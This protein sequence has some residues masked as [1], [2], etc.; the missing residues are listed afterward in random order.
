LRVKKLLF[1]Q[2]VLKKGKQMSR[3]IV[4]GNWK[5]NKTASEALLLAKEIE[6]RDLPSDV[7][8]LLAPPAVYLQNIRQVVGSKTGLYVAA[9]NCHH[10]QRGAFTGEISVEM[11]KSI[12]IQHVIIGHSERREYFKETNAMIAKKVDLL[13]SKEMTPIFCCGEPLPIRKKGKHVKYVATQIKESLFH[14]VHAD[15]KKV[16]IAYEPIWAIG[17]GLTATPE[18][19]QDMHFEL[20]KVIR[21]K[22]GNEIADN[23]S[24]L[25]GGSCNAAN[26]K[27]LFAQPDI[28]GGL[29]GGASLKVDDFC[30]IVNSF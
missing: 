6:Q 21:K 24:I 27:T 30:T 10:E 20:R 12:D 22:Y 5:M 4:A 13:L 2:K 14:L 18:Q 23:I 11:I 8:V 15:I 16:V 17:T 25:Y 9:Q 7:T 28:D 26:A 3:K 19:A 1:K 29:I